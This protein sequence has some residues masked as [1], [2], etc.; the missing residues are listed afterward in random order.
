VALKTILDMR[1]S[2]YK[3]VYRFLFVI[4]ILTFSVV[5]S[6]QKEIYTGHGLS[7]SIAK[8]NR[9]RE[10]GEEGMFR[11]IDGSIITRQHIK[12][13][14]VY[15]K[16]SQ[17]LELVDEVSS[18][19]DQEI[20]GPMVSRT[21][22]EFNGKIYGIGSHTNT[23]EKTNHIYLI[24]FD[25]QALKWKSD[26]TEIGS[27]VED[28]FR[29][30]A[31]MFI[32]VDVSS[33]ESKLLVCH[34]LPEKDGY[35]RFR[36]I[37]F[38]RQ[39]K[40]LW[41]ADHEMRYKDNIF[42][43][44]SS[45]WTGGTGMFITLDQGVSGGFKITNG[46]QVVTW[47]NPK[48][49]DENVQTVI[50]DRDNLTMNKFSID[51]D[52]E[53]Y[54]LEFIQAT[55][56]PGMWFY[57]KWDYKKDQGVFICSVDE[58]SGSVSAPRLIEPPTQVIGDYHLE[59]QKDI[60]KL[61]S[62]GKNIDISWSMPIFQQQTQNG[63]LVIAIEKNYHKTVTDQYGNTRTTY[64]S[65]G[66]M[67]LAFGPDL[68]LEWSQ[69]IKKKQ[70]GN[71][72]RTQSAVIIVRNES[73]YCLFNDNFKNLRSDWDGQKIHGYSA[74]NNPIALIQ[75]EIGSEG[76]STREQAWETDDTYEIPID[77]YNRYPEELGENDYVLWVNKGAFRTIMKFSFD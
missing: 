19:I 74:P 36:F 28:Y 31:N 41:Q 20:P 70:K 73:I 29:D 6:G 57:G 47:G 9:D 42:F 62:K 10:G 64:H 65:D 54:G 15:R 38:D 40:V 76:F 67:F 39:M 26:K 1:S 77:P 43:P 46:G 11:V 35:L 3:V 71:S 16:Y 60:D 30:D 25:T 61:I 58:S 18:L 69:A 17:N 8:Q 5:G 53:L 66:I 13:D 56:G 75:L 45:S 27:I 2:I 23:S 33:D 34:K 24:E 55:Y 14:V 7:V 59:T 49:D 63:G 50:I 68:D 44:C 72:R 52:K 48:R 21:R 22:F 32:D 12:D 37:V 4:A 51:D